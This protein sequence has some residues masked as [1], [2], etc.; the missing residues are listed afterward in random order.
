MTDSTHSDDG[1]V[2]V[3]EEPAPVQNDPRANEIEAW[4]AELDDGATVS[5]SDVASFDDVPAERCVG[6]TMRVRGV[7]YHVAIQ[8]GERVRVFTRRAMRISGPRRTQ[9]PINMPVVE[10]SRAG[11]WTRLYVHPD[12]GPIF[13]TR[14]ISL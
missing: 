8:A 13:S 1:Q 3:F 5:S 14:D 2:L 9:H 4:V 12:H 6:V 11:A 10:I 7:E